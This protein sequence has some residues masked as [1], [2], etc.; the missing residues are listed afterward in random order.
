[1]SRLRVDKQK[2]IIHEVSKLLK[3]FENEDGF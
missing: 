1:M 2:L 3:Q